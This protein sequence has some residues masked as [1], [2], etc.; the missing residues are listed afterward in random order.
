MMALVV[1]C[2][3]TGER[4]PADGGR[5]GAD[6]G[7]QTVD[8]SRRV[9]DAGSDAVRDG[10]EG[11]PGPREA[12][13]SDAAPD[14]KPDAG[15]VA[16]P[17]TSPGTVVCGDGGASDGSLAGEDCPPSV[18]AGVFPPNGGYDLGSGAASHV[19]KMEADLGR[20]LSVVQ[21]YRATSS[22]D[23]QYIGAD[24]AQIFAHGAVAHLNIEP[25]GYKASQYANAS[26]DPQIAADLTGTGEAVAAALA[27]AP[28]SRMLITFGAEMNGNWTDWG[29]LPPA[30]FIAFYQ[31][32]HDL[33]MKALASQ[34]PPI[35]PRRLRWVFGPDG[36]GS[37][38]S[39]DVYYPGHGYA[40]YL[41][42]SAYRTS[43]DQTA[44]DAV[45]AP[46]QALF[47]ALAFPDDW[48]QARFIVLQTGTGVYAGDDRGAWLTDLYTSTL[49]TAIFHGVIYFDQDDTGGVAWSLLTTATP[50]Q[51]QPGYP[52]W[53]AA[54]DALPRVSPSLAST[55]EPYFWDVRVEHARYAEVQSLRAANLTSGC[56]VPPATPP[57]FCP[58]DPLTREAAAV[59]LVGAFGLTPT[60][61][62]PLFTD[63]ATTN[64][65]RPAIETVASLGALPGCTATTFCPTDPIARVDLATALAA[66]R[67]PT[68]ASGAPPFADLGG[69]DAATVAAI[70]AL[71]Q[72][73]WIDGCGNGNF[74][75]K[76]GATRADGAAWIVHTADVPPA[77]PL[78]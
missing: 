67:K 10:T 50:P 20:P 73:R 3:A 23:Q 49:A 70:A 51:P 2:S 12:G 13:R 53:V 31:E 9:A 34:S 7:R 63:V 37:C 71:A 52:K 5:T 62:G 47:S 61:S 40:D 66:L 65:S 44:E 11:G 36:D 16:A 38:E 24:V 28:G 33:T 4:A 64:P 56:S 74:C 14:H 58:A 69:L 19:L 55:F 60:S 41:G 59:F 75:P 15:P 39:P 22:A 46:A 42:M 78:D 72:F 21:T 8:G 27:A 6:T 35:D 18:F 25:S 29:C 45:V 68:K 30:T 57:L 77:S 17:W 1:G 32:M 26:T 54:V 48:Q 76:A 43:V